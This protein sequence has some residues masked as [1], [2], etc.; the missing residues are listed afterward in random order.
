VQLNATV[1][2]EG[3][4]NVSLPFQVTFY[5][6]GAYLATKQVSNLSA[7]TSV[8]VTAVWRAR[9]GK[10][11]AGVRVDSGG[12][13]V[14]SDESDNTRSLALPSVTGRTW[15]RAPPPSVRPAPPTGRSST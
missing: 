2:N 15:S 4:S 8:N 10:H 7:S 13:V 12:V 5:I 1:K 11:T 3:S 6:D 14:E 9:P